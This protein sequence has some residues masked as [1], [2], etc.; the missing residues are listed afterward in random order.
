MQRERAGYALVAIAACSW[1]TWRYIL[2][3]AEHFAPHLD[4]RVESAVVMLVITVAGFAAMALERRS[5]PAGHTPLAWLGVA[6]LGA[7]DAL[8]VMLLFVAYGKTSVSIAVTT[9]YLAPIFVAALA[10]LTLGER[11]RKSVV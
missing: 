11:D 8:N 2:L 9:H 6:W 3:A 10:P 5:E 7:A 1:G 4:A